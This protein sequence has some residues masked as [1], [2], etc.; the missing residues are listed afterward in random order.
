MMIVEGHRS[1]GTRWAALAKVVPGRPEN[2]VKN[3]WYACKR[4]KFE[5]KALLRPLY[6][7][8]L[9]ELNIVEKPPTKEALLEAKEKLGGAYPGDE[10]VALPKEAFASEVEKKKFEAKLATLS[11]KKRLMG[12]DYTLDAADDE[13]EKEE[14]D[15]D[16]NERVEASDSPAKEKE[17]LEKLL[18][19]HREKELREKQERQ[20]YLLD[21]QLKR[22]PI[23]KEAKSVRSN[24][25]GI[26]PTME[27][28][29]VEIKSNALVN[30]VKNE[31]DNQAA[32]WLVRT[33]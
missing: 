3:H 19:E 2:A 25:K 31:L 7:Y 33:R 24:T 8:Q 11:Q 21:Q 10:P 27:E 32:A 20:Q 26:S 9:R 13:E 29:D 14:E 16:T 17:R 5:P 22:R 15:E 30:A 18:K 6:R 28:M 12:V 23:P 4:T 1:L